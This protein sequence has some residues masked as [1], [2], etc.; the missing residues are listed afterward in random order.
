VNSIDSPHSHGSE[1]VCGISQMEVR[2]A[3][4]TSNRTALVVFIAV[5]RISG[6]NRFRDKKVSKKKHSSTIF[7][8]VPG[9]S[10]NFGKNLPLTPKQSPS[11]ADL[12]ALF[13]LLCRFLSQY[14]FPFFIEITTIERLISTQNTIQEKIFKPFDNFSCESV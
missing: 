10:K 9:L 12:R 13:D 11:D 8:V 2:S 1:P 7:I 14:Q 6:V 3:I 4:F 5:K